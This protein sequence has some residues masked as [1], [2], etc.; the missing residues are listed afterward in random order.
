[1]KISFDKMSDRYKYMASDTRIRQSGRT[2]ALKSGNSY[3]TLQI[4]P[5][6]NKAAEQSFIKVLADR[7]SADV[8][9]AAPAQRVDE[10]REQVG[11]GTYRVD[12]SA[13]ASR[14]LLEKGEI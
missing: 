9:E 14:I 11:A 3:D 7:L 2:V 1:M 6:G 4:S 5:Q 8:R 13:I 12:V 10:L